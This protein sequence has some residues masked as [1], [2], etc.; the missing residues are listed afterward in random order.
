[1]QCAIV[2]VANVEDATGYP[3]GNDASAQCCDCDAH[4]CEA[5]AQN[6]ECCGEVFC[7]TCFAYHTSAYH[8]K[9]PAAE[10]RRLRKSA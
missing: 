10:H 9:Q 7:S 4:I 6:C 1:M 5:H 2:E 3:C 8:Q